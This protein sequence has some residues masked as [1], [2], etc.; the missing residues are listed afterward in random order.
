M[1]LCPIISFILEPFSIMS[2]SLTLSNRLS[3]NIP[4]GSLLITLL[5]TAAVMAPLAPLKQL[6][7]ASLM[8]TTTPPPLLFL[9]SIH[10]FE[11]LNSLIQ[12]FTFNLLSIEYQSRAAARLV[13]ASLMDPMLALPEY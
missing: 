6:T 11:I 4:A 3:I 8:L 2:Q 5:S 1:E 12:L 9:L 10:S 7:L 13:L